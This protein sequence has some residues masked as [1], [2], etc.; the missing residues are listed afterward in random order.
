MLFGL[1]LPPFRRR[2]I[3][4]WQHQKD[5]GEHLFDIV[6][7]DE[8]HHY[9]T[10]RA[11][12]QLAP[13][14]GQPATELRTQPAGSIVPAHV[15]FRNS[16]SAT[17]TVMCCP[18]SG[19]WR[20]VWDALSGRITDESQFKLDVSVT[21]KREADAR[22]GAAM[23]RETVLGA[24]AFKEMKLLLCTATP[25]IEPAG[26]IPFDPNGKLKPYSLLNAIHDTP[27]NA[28]DLVFL[29][30]LDAPRVVGSLTRTNCSQ[31]LPFARSLLRPLVNFCLFVRLQML[32]ACGGC[33]RH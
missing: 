18:A 12:P 6:V 10:A 4:L 9:G 21:R 14:H 8:A 26:S 29:D 22:M 28:K 5:T 27:P 1:L 24:K 17:E 3:H 11:F 20:N 30:I 19:T 33:E 2:L 25:F 13:P 23:S 32:R 15:R 16:I 7:M 31:V